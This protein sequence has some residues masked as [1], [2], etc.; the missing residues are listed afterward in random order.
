MGFCGEGWLHL[1]RCAVV[2][3]VAVAP[4]FAQRSAID[5]E[6][7]ATNPLNGDSGKVTVLIFI[8]TDCP[9]SSRYA[10]TIQKIANQYASAARFW[11]VYPDKAETSQSVQKYLT[12][13]GYHL[14]AL[15]DPD[16]VLVKQGHVQITPEIAVFDRNGRLT[17]DGRIDDWYISLQQARPAPTSHEL[18]DAIRLATL[19][20]RMAPREV[21]GVG[22]YISDLD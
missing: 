9:V 20:K 2:L 3:L 17:Y 1:R 18:E 4:A 14:A 8:R 19:G 11:L 22:C 6:G 10:P 12:E 5:L 7:R 21:R 13:Y 15:R 16:H